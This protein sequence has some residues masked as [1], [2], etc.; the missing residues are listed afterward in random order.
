[1]LK[2]PFFKLSGPRL[3]YSSIK[4]DV[5]IREIPF[6]SK[7]N[8]LLEKE[9]ISLTEL[10]KY[11]GRIVKTG[12]RIKINGATLIFPVTGRITHIS[13]Y[14][15]YLNKGYYS[16]FIETK[17]DEWIDI[18]KDYIPVSLPGCKDMGSLF[19]FSPPVNHVIVMGMDTDLFITTNQLALR[20]RIEEIKKGIG[21][22]HRLAKIGKVSFVI[23]PE[24]VPYIRDMGCEFFILKPVYPNAIPKL[25]IKAFFKEVVPAGRE[26]RDIGI[27]FISAEAVAN[28]GCLAE[29][30]LVFDKLLT[31]I[32]KDYSTV[33]VK[34]RIGTPIAHILNTLNIDVSD[35]DRI[36]LGGPMRGHAIYSLDSPVSYDTDAIFIQDRSEIIPLTNTRC[37]NCGE[38]VK[39]CPVNVPVNMLIRVLENGLFEEAAIEYD[40]LSCIECG[41]CSYVCI[42]RIPI[43]HYIML[44]KYELSKMEKG[45]V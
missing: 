11:I 41:L 36:V 20:D 31:V 25:V 33:H 16:L 44:G 21:H 35:G 4:G 28:M 29:G 8:L 17:E 37:V 7:A 3:Y 15:G 1:M 40:L 30:K 14:T 32:N 43:F 5:S 19:S 2:R 22:L 39:V 42:A 24:L 13:E 12:E 26:I 27:E 23:P 6:P 38:C 9:N 45:N 10:C 34:A 18:P